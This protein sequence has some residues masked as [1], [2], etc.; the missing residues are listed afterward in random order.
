MALGQL[1]VLHLMAGLGVAVAV[2]LQT[3]ARHSG[4]RVFQVV[5]AV[6]FWPF[7]LALL[8]GR[9]RAEE[10]PTEPGAH[11]GPA[12]ELARA[13][14][15]VDAELEGAWQSLDGWAEGVLTREKGRLQEMRSVW[16]AQA[17]RI[18]DMDRLLSRPEY[19]VLDNNV[20][21]VTSADG[22]GERLRGSQQVIRHN[23]ER[24][25]QV[26]Q[27]TLK[28]LLGTLA[29]VSELVSMIHLARFTGAPASRGE[30]LVAQIAAAVDGLSAMTWQ[31]GGHTAQPLLIQRGIE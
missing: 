26:R 10:V 14:A 30:D 16:A 18:R 29:G 6:L 3:T 31:T 27:Q 5:T 9:R 19:A 11:S 28:D 20:F 23:L 1:L 8:L 21:A 7:Y 12:D 2:Y 17:Q 15:Q 25:R 24:L 13:I 4:L 22:A